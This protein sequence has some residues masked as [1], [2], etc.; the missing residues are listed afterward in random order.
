MENDATALAQ[1][2][3]KLTRF[4]FSHEILLQS[5]LYPPFY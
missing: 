4:H 5:F 3:T 1:S 2:H